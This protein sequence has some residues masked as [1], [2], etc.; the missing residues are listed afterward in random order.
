[1]R[2]GVDGR[3]F[4]RNTSHRRAMFRNLGNQVIVNE[5]IVTTVEKAKEA[6]RVI[7]RLITLGKQGDVHSRR[8]AFDRCRDRDVVVKL[9]GSLAERYKDRAGGYT[10]VLKKSDLRWGDAAQMAVLELVDHPELDRKK[11]V[12]EG[13]KKAAKKE[14]TADT[15]D[16]AGDK[17]ESKITDPFSGIRKMFS[18]KKKSGGGRDPSVRSKK[19][20]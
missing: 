1:M 15:P 12:V 5:Q 13:S 17:K 19:G 6:R 11:K 10:R 8:L 3:K 7:D 20:G 4:G 2:H 9:F 18:S 14:A 16:K